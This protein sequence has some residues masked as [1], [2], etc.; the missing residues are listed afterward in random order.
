MPTSAAL[1]TMH[2]N[3]FPLDVE[4]AEAKR[5]EL[6]AAAAEPYSRM[7][8]RYPLETE[9]APSFAPTSRW[10]ADWSMAAVQAH[11][12]QI[13]A[14]TPSGK[15]QWSKA[16][17]VRQERAGSEVAA[18][19]LAYRRDTKR[20][21]FLNSWL[22]KATPEG[23]VYAMYN[24]G[25]TVTGRLSSSDP[26]MQ[27]V[28]SEIKPAYWGGPGY[29][30]ADLDYSQI[31]M[32]LAA[33]VADCEPMIE[34]FLRGDD[35]HRMLAAVAT[36]KPLGEITKD[37]RQGGKAGNFGFLFG[38]EAQ[39]FQTYAETVYGVSFTPDEAY[40]VREAFFDQWD[41]MAQ[42]HSRTVA[43]AKA[44]GQIV[45]P[46]GRV[47]R[48]PE[49][50]FEGYPGQHAERQ[51]INSPV[52]GFA[53]DIMQTANASISG[54]LPGVAAVPGVRTLATVHDSLVVAVPIEG[55]QRS[56]GLCMRRMLDVAPVL[57]RLGCELRV[58]LAVKAEVGTRWGLTD[59]GVIE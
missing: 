53:S 16:V 44:T 59:V 45:S 26:N 58:P 4:W 19:L 3:G 54:H 8:D 20:V 11:D 39:G 31:E 24:A 23:K 37:D 14:L 29:Y 57:K 2:Q 15:P 17:L 40:A 7:V 18:D 12:L 28:T 46:I 1:T 5:T 6:L 27:Q 32:R 21:E 36:G 43:R 9:E 22:D 30:V 35:L 38:M 33:H 49:I 25:R 34:A 47:R 55:W 48:L 50:H 41:G 13:G 51:S 42:W 10:F 52:Q 56:V